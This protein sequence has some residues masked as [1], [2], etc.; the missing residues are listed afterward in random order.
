MHFAKSCSLY[1]RGRIHISIR[2]KKIYQA[3]AM[4]IYKALYR[5]SMPFWG[6]T[7]AKVRVKI[8]AME[9]MAARAP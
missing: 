6:R 3:P 7:K 4:N 8:P 9:T 5:I 1:W 2:T